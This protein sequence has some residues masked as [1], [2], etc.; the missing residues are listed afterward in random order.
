M[1]GIVS[2]L[3]TLDTGTRMAEDYYNILGVT[4]EA[5]QEDIQKAYRALARKYHPDL[6]PDDAT[7]KTKFQE[8]QKAFEVLND[9]SK[10]EFY[11]RYGTSFE[12]MGA[13]GPQPGRRAGNPFQGG[14]EFD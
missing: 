6:N 14:Q 8:V 13:G 12:Q 4:R 7:A 3:S 10:R 1:G 5:S 2:S 9:S 11:D